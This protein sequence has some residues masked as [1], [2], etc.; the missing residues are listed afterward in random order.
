M[1]S[2]LLDRRQFI[3]DIP[4]HY[5]SLIGDM[6]ETNLYFMNCNPPGIGGMHLAINHF[7]VYPLTSPITSPL[8]IPITRTFCKPCKSLDTLGFVHKLSDL[9]VSHHRIHLLW[10]IFQGPKILTLAAD[11][12]ELLLPPD[13][14]SAGSS[15]PGVSFTSITS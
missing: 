14:S 8:P 6:F 1:K 3:F 10:Q 4:L 11:R 9:I 12:E 15:A 7:W 13:P 5:T 2:C